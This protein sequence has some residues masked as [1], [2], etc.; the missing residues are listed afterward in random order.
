MVFLVPTVLA[1]LGATALPV[2]IHL[3]NK[4]RV[5]VV[6][7][8]AMRFLAE[9]V[10]QHQR[11]LQLENWLLLA[12]RCLFFI[13]LAVAFARPVLH[14]GGVAGTVTGPVVAVLLLDQSASMGQS[15]GVSTRFEQGKTAAR[16]ILDGLEPGS[17]AALLLVSDR[18]NP[19][20]ARPTT[21]LP[22]VRRAVEVAELTDRAGNLTEAIKAAVDVLRPISGGH[23][24]IDLL[25][26]NQAS[27]WPEWEQ[28]Q[29]ALAGVSGVRLRLAA[30]GDRGEDNLA[31]T[32]LRAEA[33]VAASGQPFGCLVEVSN[34]GASVAA[35][36]RVTLAVDGGPPVDETMLDHLDPG[37]TR[38]VR[39]NVRFPK[40]GFYTLTA[41]IPADRLPV[42]NQRSLAVH[43]IDRLDVAVVEGGSAAAA[44]D[45]DAFFLVNALVPVLPARRAG[46][47]LKTETVQPAWL[48]E[49]AL[50]HYGLVFLSNVG[51]LAPNAVGALQKYVGEGGNLVIFPGPRVQP[52]S[53]NHDGGL[54]GLLP[55]KLGELR[56]PGRAGKFASWQAADY[57]HPV[58]AL[59]N[60]GQNGNLGSI[61]TTQYFPLELSSVPVGGVAGTS[62]VVVA[63][64]DGTP[65][66]ARAVVRQG[67]RYPFRQQ[68]HD[69]VEQFAD[70]SGLRAV[71]ATPRRL[72]DRGKQRCG[73]V[74]AAARRCFSDG[75][76]E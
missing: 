71:V 55:A 16:K 12:L 73:R 40:A 72:S 2:A 22:L 7:W 61:H 56:D 17:Q 5:Q 59:W 25:T 65:A 24:E 62:R 19:V 63:Y 69:G 20:I 64:T 6:R 11:R 23:Q 18:V 3:L 60:D 14:P 37:Q 35:G 48:Q 75:R 58:T 41:T 15:N 68:R 36:V 53:Y 76:E 31:V 66:A 42:D 70:P 38:T 28:A 44:Q 57:R 21:N 32:A 47:Y 10:S 46:Y 1:G 13:L 45:R 50:D 43:V 52:D 74:A 4:H 49:A 26:D 33:A 54:G 29:S 9:I 67:T 30:L 8:G 34:Y 27:G 51:T 39:L